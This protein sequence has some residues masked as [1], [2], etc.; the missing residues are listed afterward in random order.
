MYRE[1]KSQVTR[2]ESI[3]NANS[4]AF[5]D[6][7]RK[8]SQNEWEKLGFIFDL[9]KASDKYLRE[10]LL[11]QGYKLTSLQEASMKIDDIVILLKGGNTTVDSEWA[12]YELPPY[13]SL[14]VSIEGKTSINL[15]NHDLSFSKLMLKFKEVPLRLKIARNNENKVIGSA[16]TGIKGLKITV[17]ETQV[18]ESIYA[19]QVTI[20]EEKFLDLLKVGILLGTNALKFDNFNQTQFVYGL[21]V[22]YKNFGIWSI[23][24]QNNSMYGVSLSTSIGSFF[25]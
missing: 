23:K 5:L 17:L 22:T 8:V 16:E 7:L 20:K 24:D 19:P 2:L 15:K 6:S 10:E 11:K 18:D 13:D 25:K 4:E 14:I 9:Q 3:N 12:T 1:I 21:E